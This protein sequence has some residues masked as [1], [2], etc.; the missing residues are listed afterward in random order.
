MC[1][2]Y[3]IHGQ[4][5]WALGQKNTGHDLTL[6]ISLSHWMYSL[7]GWL[8][9]AKVYLNIVYTSLSEG[10]EPMYI[11]MAGY[12]LRVDW[13]TAATFRIGHCYINI[14]H[15]PLCNMLHLVFCII[16]VQIWS[17]RACQLRSSRT[18]HIQYQATGSFCSTTSRTLHPSE[19]HFYFII[20]K[21]VF[22]LSW[23]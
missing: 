14:L 23:F 5:E 17:Q 1:S 22:C 4:S 12:A 11:F 8:A 18:G 7:D 2:S 16:S 3:C 15:I 13:Q 9:A 19:I 21:C 6:Y 20:P 10:M